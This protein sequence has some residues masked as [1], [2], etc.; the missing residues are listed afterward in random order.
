M[1][2]D[3][4]GKSGVFSHHRE[5]HLTPAPEPAAGFFVCTPCRLNPRLQPV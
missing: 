3:A 1:A 5:K 2:L 4:P